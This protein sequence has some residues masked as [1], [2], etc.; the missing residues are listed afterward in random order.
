MIDAGSRIVFGAKRIRLGQSGRRLAHV[1]LAR[2]DICYQAGTVFA[3]RTDLPPRTLYARVNVVRPTIYGLRDVLL[4]FYGWERHINPTEVL[5]VQIL[6]VPN[7]V[8]R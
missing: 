3:Q 2:D 4:F 8:R 1:E 6:S 7:E 5:K